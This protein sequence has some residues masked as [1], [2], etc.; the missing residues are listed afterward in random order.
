MVIFLTSHVGNDEMSL[1]WQYYDVDYAYQYAT[2]H[3]SKSIIEHFYAGVVHNVH[4]T[5]D[6]SVIYVIFRCTSSVMYA[7]E[8]KHTTRKSWSKA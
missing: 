5:S 7:L 6:H 3:D 1:L 4:N 2:T 8:V